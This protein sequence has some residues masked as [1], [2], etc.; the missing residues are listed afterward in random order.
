MKL[1]VPAYGP[2]WIAALRKAAPRAELAVCADDREAV[3]QVHD[4]DGTIGFVGRDVLKAG[5][6]L[7]WVQT[8]SAGVDKVIAH[9]PKHVT[10]TCA[11]GA[12]SPQL[13]E[14]HLAM[15]LA[16]A[17]RLGTRRRDAEFRVL[18]GASLHVVG[19]GGTGQALSKKARA[20]GMKLTLK[21][22]AADFVAICCPLTPQTRGMFDRRMFARLKPGAILTNAARGAIVDT[23]ALV[24]ALGQGTLGGA[25]LDVTDPEPLPQGHPLWQ[26]ENV[27]ITPHVGGYS[28]NAD[29]Q[30]FAI[31][32]DNV[33]RFVRGRPLRNV[34]DRREGY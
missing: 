8:E 28:P 30:V 16:L 9:V 12:Y 17:R 23:D 34:V 14:H 4:A 11:R 33:R 31:V 22:E 29:A 10:L 3:A 21:L 19:K 18:E 2:E 26:M 1:V 25:G 7:R 24:E 13:A 5:R 6:R 15:M 20:L 32:L 27:I